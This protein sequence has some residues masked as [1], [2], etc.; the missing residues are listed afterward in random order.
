MKRKSIKR[1]DSDLRFKTF[2]TIFKFRQ[3]RERR[4][5]NI[6]SLIVDN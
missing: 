5:E 3:L 1:E 6:I 4:K 2:K